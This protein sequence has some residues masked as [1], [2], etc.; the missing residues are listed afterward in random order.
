M[1]DAAAKGRV[2]LLQAVNLI[3]TNGA[4]RFGLYPQ[5]GVIR[6]GADADLYPLVDLAATTTI[7]KTELFTQARLCDYLY[8][9]LSFQGKVLTT[10][11]GGKTVYHEGDVMGQPGWGKVRAP[12]TDF[13]TG[14]RNARARGSELSE[15]F[16]RCLPKNR[17][18]REQRMPASR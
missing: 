8:D 13:S 17:V 1:L 9:G 15:R 4:K 6:E 14:A 3:S 16:R 12:S 7:D 11:L 2:T 10:M 5:K 18:K